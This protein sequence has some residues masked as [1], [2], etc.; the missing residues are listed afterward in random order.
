VKK[1]Q[2][3]VVDMNNGHVYWDVQIIGMVSGFEE[4]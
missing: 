4:I 1:F 2:I 3:E